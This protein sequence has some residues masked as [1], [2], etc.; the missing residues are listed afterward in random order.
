MNQR[1]QMWVKI[2]TICGSDLR[3]ISTKVWPAE[4]VTQLL[5]LLLQR[6]VESSNQEVKKNTK[7]CSY[8]QDC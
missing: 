8:L 1:R 2:E 4:D 7:Y 6:Q 3:Q 5:Q